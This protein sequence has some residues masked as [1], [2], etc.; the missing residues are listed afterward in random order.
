MFDGLILVPVVAKCVREIYTFV[1]CAFGDTDITGYVKLGESP[2][3]LSRRSRTPKAR[4]SDH[5]L[6][7]GVVTPSLIDTN[8]LVVVLWIQ[9]VN[10]HSGGPR[11]STGY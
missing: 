9:K 7:A 6:D 5:R 3:P 2:S 11:L 1:H 8:L 4:P 10:R